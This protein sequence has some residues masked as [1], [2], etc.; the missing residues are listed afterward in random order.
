MYEKNMSLM[1]INGVSSISE[2]NKAIG[3]KFDKT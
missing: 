1:M 3:F 2:T